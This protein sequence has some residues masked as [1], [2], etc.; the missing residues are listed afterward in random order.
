LQL[1]CDSL[2][3]ILAINAAQNQCG[4]VLLCTAGPGRNLNESRDTATEQGTEKIRAL[5]HFRI[6]VFAFEQ[7]ICYSVFGRIERFEFSLVFN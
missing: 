7:K 3:R 5:F 2:A 4:A 6:Q 1:L